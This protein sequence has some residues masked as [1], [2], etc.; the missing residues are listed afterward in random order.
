MNDQQGDY[1]ENIAQEAG[2]TAGRFGAYAQFSK[3]VLILY[4][5]LTHS[6]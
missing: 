4:S 1:D 2:Y 6:L 5:S 3:L